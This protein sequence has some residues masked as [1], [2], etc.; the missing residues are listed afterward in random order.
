MAATQPRRDADNLAI[1]EKLRPVYEG[2]KAQKI[3]SESDVARFEQELANAKA[4]AEAELGTSNLDEI[5]AR[6]AADRTANTAA[7]DEFEKKIGEIKRA[8]E[9]LGKG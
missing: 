2:L 8:S 6:I 9:A 5:R 1:L 4:A 7:V 3:R